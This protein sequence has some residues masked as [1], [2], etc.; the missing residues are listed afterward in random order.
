M[1]S[2]TDDAFEPVYM[3]IISNMQECLGKS[4]SWII[5]S[6]LDNAN[7]ILNCKPLSGNS[8]IKLLKELDHPK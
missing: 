4:S 1:E 2:D 3:T 6:V 8:Y 5:D 7:N